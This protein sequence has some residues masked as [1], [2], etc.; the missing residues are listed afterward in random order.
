MKNLT[1]LAR[2]ILLKQIINNFH[3]HLYINECIKNMLNK[4]GGGKDTF[5]TNKMTK[6]EKTEFVNQLEEG[7]GGGLLIILGK[8]Y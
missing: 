3:L 2:N 7:A 6:T 4:G 5:K 1:K 8:I